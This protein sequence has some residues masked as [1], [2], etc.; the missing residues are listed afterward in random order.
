LEKTNVLCIGQERDVDDDIM[1]HGFV[2]KKKLT[3]LG[4]YITNNFDDD[5]D[6]NANVFTKKIA[7]NVT[8]VGTF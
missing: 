8:K 5:L 1:E 7:D 2:V 3:V 6:S 4:M